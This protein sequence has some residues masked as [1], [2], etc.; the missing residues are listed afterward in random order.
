MSGTSGGRASVQIPSD[1]IMI[2]SEAPNNINNNSTSETDTQPSESASALAPAQNAPPPQVSIGEPAVGY[3][4][5]QS[6]IISHNY[7]KKIILSDGSNRGK[8]LVCLK[9]KNKEVLF[10]M[11]DGNLRGVEG[12]LQSSH[13]SYYEK[14][15]EQKAKVIELRAQNK[16]GEKNESSRQQKLVFG[17]NKTMKLDVREDPD[18][19]KRYDKAR[20]LF[21]AKTFTAFNA[22]KSDEIY[23]KALLPKTYKKVQNK[24]VSTMSRHTDQMADDIRRDLMS[25]IQSEL[26]TKEHNT[27]GFSTDMYSSLNQYSIIAL[28]IHFSDKNLDPWKFVLYAEYFGYGRRHTGQNIQ[29]ALE[30]MFKEAGLDGANVH[31]FILMDNAANNKRCATLFEGDHTVIWCAIHTLQ[32]CI[33]DAFRIKVGH[34]RVAKVL[35]K[36]KDVSNL[37]RRA[38]ARRDE[39]KEACAV[40]ETRF[41]MPVKPGKT[42]WNSIE[43]N[44]NSCLVIQPALT[45]L[46]AYDRS[47]TWSETVPSVREFDVAGAV[48]KCLQ[49]LKIATKT[50]ESDRKASLHQVVK[51]LY[52][53]KTALGDLESNSPHVK[54]FAKNLRKQVEKRF[55]RCGTSDDLLAISHFLDPSEKGCV[56]HEYR[57]AYQR[58]ISAIKEM[59]K[60]FDPTPVQAQ[61]GDQIDLPE[62]DEALTGTE[63]LKKRR[64]ISGDTPDPLPVASRVEIEIERFEKLP[65]EQT[66]PL[67]YWRENK[68][69]FD[70]LRKI[71]ADVYSIP[72]SSSSSER[73][74]SAA[75]KACRKDRLRMSPRT[76]SNQM[77]INLNYTDVENY[78]EKVG[79][80]KQYTGPLK[81]LAEVEFPD[82]LIR[83]ETEPPINHNVDVGFDVEDEFEFTIDSEEESESDEEE[84]DT[85]DEES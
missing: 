11:P 80:K 35:K 21:S 52:N 57:G 20:V 4:I 24:S 7:F 45:H 39:L 64:R 26:E 54:T 25:I 5:H 1:V 19:Q 60:K 30:T 6:I 31:R 44:V 13:K 50:W 82:E 43:G 2:D 73:A 61:G 18:L 51:Q 22:L 37:V 46:N 47:N 81:Q 34:I 56:L 71:A 8:C 59:A 3:S 29:F 69:S 84:T 77:M 83:F 76:I 28:T 41:I 10:K 40:T 67:D 38:E 85:S 75:T 78:K 33:K 23:V 70:I 27:F 49:P 72:A 68:G 42:R 58:T 55:P 63:R 66:D 65:L 32:L 12:H 16:R 53:V 15:I 36:C 14:Y 79:I 48:H 62:N 17:E 74:F 9:E